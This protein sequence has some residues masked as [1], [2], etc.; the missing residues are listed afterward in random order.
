M[1]DTL[2][3]WR[4]M[5]HSLVVSLAVH[6]LILITIVSGYGGKTGTFGVS[7]VIM[8]EL[9]PAGGDDAQLNAASEPTPFP[10]EPNLTPDAS[11]GP[12]PSLD[13]SASS[14]SEREP[15]VPVDDSD[16]LSNGDRI[17]VH[18]DESGNNLRNPPRI[19][20]RPMPG[21]TPAPTRPP[22]ARPGAS[23][24]P[25]VVNQA[26]CASCPPPIYPEMALKRGLEGTVELQVQV[27]PDGRVGD[28]FVTKSSGYP[29][30][31]DTAL[32]V[33]KG[34]TFFPAADDDG[35]IPSSQTISVPFR[36]TEP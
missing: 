2:P 13:N 7:G 9:L 27:L 23:P 28:I 3:A 16:R 36:L 22:T 12:A 8:L 35:P 25:Q 1:T 5:T 21:G 19:D 33:V 26:R 14:G 10:A 6:L 32:T 18:N 29:L 24:S 31:D 4:R 15:A 30:L 17:G 11:P 34:W 20:P